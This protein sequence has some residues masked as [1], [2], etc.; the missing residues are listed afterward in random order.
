MQNSSAMSSH[1]EVGVQ[2]HEILAEFG[3]EN[4]ETHS[5]KTVPREKITII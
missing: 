4:R 5:S 3:T 1:S 2:N